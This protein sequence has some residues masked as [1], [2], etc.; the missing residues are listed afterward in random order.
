MRVVRNIVG[1]ILA[2]TLAAI[3][4]VI[5]GQLQC[6]TIV[7]ILFG[8]Q[9]FRLARCGVWPF[10]RAL[11]PRDIR[12]KSLFVA[13]NIPLTPTCAPRRSAGIET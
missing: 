8:P 7:D 10:E 9:V 13:G 6:V 11:V 3:S 1:L 12:S 2:A 4:R 5:A